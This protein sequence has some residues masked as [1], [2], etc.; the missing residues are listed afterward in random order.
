MHDVLNLARGSITV[1]KNS[2]LKTGIS[3]LYGKGQCKRYRVLK[4]GGIPDTF[5]QV[6]D[7]QSEVCSLQHGAV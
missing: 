6:L 4:S 3:V 2:N 7:R 5:C 1:F